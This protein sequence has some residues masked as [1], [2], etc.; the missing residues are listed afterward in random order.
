MSDLPQ[1]TKRREDKLEY[2]VF[3]CLKVIIK[4]NY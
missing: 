4:L 1:K 3:G 2:N